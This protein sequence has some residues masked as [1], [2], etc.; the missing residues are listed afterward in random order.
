VGSHEFAA[1]GNAAFDFDLR[2]RDILGLPGDIIA[3]TLGAVTSFGNRVRKAFDPP[4]P[5]LLRFW[6]S[7]HNRRRSRRGFPTGVFIGI[8]GPA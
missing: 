8:T 4:M 1:R 3:S 5:V 6:F 2:F 7:L